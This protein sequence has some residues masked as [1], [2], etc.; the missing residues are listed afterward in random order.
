MH[1]VFQRGNMH[2]IVGRI[3]GLSRVRIGLRDQVALLGISGVFVAGVICAA[4]LQY[5]SLVQNEVTSSDRFKAH[6][7]SLSQSV[8]E[9]RQ[10][11]TEFLRK[12]SEA[13]I[14]KYAENHERQIADLARLEA[15]ATSLPDDDPLRQATSLRPVINLYATRF[16]NVVAAQRNLGFNEDDGFQGKL[17]K[18]MLS[19]RVCRS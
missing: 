10:I 13:P 17:R 1:E 8:L 9:S 11:A 7:A 5:A 18:D 3:C 15:F 4:A 6:V 16:Q 12:P 14:K 2:R 19:S